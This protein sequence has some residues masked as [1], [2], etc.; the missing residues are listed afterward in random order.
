MSL[1][2]NQPAFRKHSEGKKQEKKTPAIS[3]PQQGQGKTFWQNRWN[4]FI[5]VF[6]LLCL[7]AFENP[8]MPGD[9]GSAVICLTNYIMKCMSFF[10]RHIKV[11]FARFF[12]IGGLTL[13]SEFF[14]A[15]GKLSNKKPCV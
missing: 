1:V 12:L 10:S 11:P 2:F 6:F 15:L 5:F 3:Q 7:N 4:F 8:T 13:I 9:S 14:V